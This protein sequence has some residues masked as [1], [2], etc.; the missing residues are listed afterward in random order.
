MARLTRDEVVQELMDMEPKVEFEQGEGYEDL[1][2]LLKAERAKREP[3]EPKAEK[4]APAAKL[5]PL[6]EKEKLELAD[7]ERRS[8]LGRKMDQPTIRE[9]EKLGVLRKRSKIVPDEVKE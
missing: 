9:M 7:L 3:E 4:K 2:N 5:K 1:W 6:T 8:K